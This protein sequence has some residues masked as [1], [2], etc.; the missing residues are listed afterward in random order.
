VRRERDEILLSVQQ[1]LPLVV[2][3]RVL[4]GERHA[5]GDDLEQLDSVR[6]ERPRFQRP[7][8]DDAEDP[9]LGDQR[10]AQQRP[11]TLV[12]EDRVEDVGVVDVLDHDGYAFRGDPACEAAADRNA[13]ALLDL[14]LE[15]LGG[16]RDELRPLRVEEQHRAGVGPER[17]ADAR[18]QLGEQLVER[19]VCERRVRDRLELPKGLGRRRTA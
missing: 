7:D 3:E 4:D 9:A 6:R 11:D 5:V 13:D 15:P 12:A 1:S 17:V 8:V 19:E 10:R 14:L 18:Q 16:A 2:D